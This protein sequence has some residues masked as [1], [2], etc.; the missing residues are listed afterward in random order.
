VRH[1]EWKIQSANF[2]KTSNKRL[3]GALTILWNIDAIY[4]HKQDQTVTDEVDYLRRGWATAEI[5]V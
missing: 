5:N 1:N 4:E 3:K 2:I